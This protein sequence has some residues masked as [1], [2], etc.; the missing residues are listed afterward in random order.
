MSYPKVKKEILLENITPDDEQLSYRQSLNAW[1]MINKLMDNVKVSMSHTKQCE[2]SIGVSDVENII[3]YIKMSLDN[4]VKNTITKQQIPNVS[5]PNNIK[6]NLQKISQ[7]N[8]NKTMKQTHTIRLTESQLHR[9]INEAVKKVLRESENP[10]QYYWSISRC[11]GRKNNPVDW[12]CM[13]CVEESS[14]SD[15]ASQSEFS[16]PQEAFDDGLTQLRYYSD[17]LYML[18]VYYFT[19]NGAGE[20]VS[21]YIACK[22]YDNIVLQQP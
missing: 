13:S 4:I 16:T 10:I 17:G 6:S 5:N 9:V 20:Y 3:N 18:Q 22:A 1:N 7:T 19:P 15:D 21:G 2:K 11:K 8:E 14:T 12:E